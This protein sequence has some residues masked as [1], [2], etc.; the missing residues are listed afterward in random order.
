[1]WETGYAMALGKPVI[2][3]TQDLATLPF[4]V[5]DIQALAY[6]RTQL[7]S[8]LGKPLRE[9]VRDTMSHATT[10]DNSVFPAIQ[11]E[12]ARLVTGLGIQLADLKEIMSQVVKAW[13]GEPGHSKEPTGLP[14]E[15][16]ELEGAW[17]NESSNSSVYVLSVAGRLVAPY[18]YGGNDKL[19]AHY[20]DWQGLGDRF[21]FARFK[22]LSEPSICG[23]TFLRL[24]SPDTLKGAW[25]LNENFEEAPTHP[26]TA[27]GNLVIWRRQRRTKVPKWATEF[28][29]RVR[30]G[31][32]L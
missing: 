32:V 6:D 2:I 16:R 5:R 24:L 14:D 23:F 19:T 21:F 31:A 10:P 13:S 8:S 30:Q 15:S 3:V 18:C 25:W 22:W 27:S 26:Q 28:F 1:M 7:H 29:D 20:F 12:Q 11:E 4:D 9:V 17:L